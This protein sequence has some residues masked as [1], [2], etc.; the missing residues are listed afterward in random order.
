MAGNSVL[1][2]HQADIIFYGVDLLDYSAHE[3]K[4]PQ[5]RRAGRSY[6]RTRFWNRVMVWGRVIDDWNMQF[7]EDFEGFL[8]E[9]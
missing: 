8:R 9:P 1:S 7:G 6:R 3:F 2:V 5:F 4:I